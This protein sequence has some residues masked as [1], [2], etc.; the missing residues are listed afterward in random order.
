MTSDLFPSH[1]VPS[2]STEEWNKDTEN[3]YFTE[4]KEKEQNYV[5]N[6]MH[7]GTIFEQCMC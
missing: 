3:K 1:S 7:K 2:C 6:D 5:L 4:R